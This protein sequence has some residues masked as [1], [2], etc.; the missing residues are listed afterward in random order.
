MKTQNAV[1]KANICSLYKAPKA[2]EAS[3]WDRNEGGKE[4]LQFITA[5]KQ[6]V[7]PQLFIHSE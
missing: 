6:G 7:N 5:G 3:L 2:I 1:R 4:C